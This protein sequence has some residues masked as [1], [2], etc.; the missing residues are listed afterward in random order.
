MLFFSFFPCSRFSARSASGR[1]FLLHVQDL[2][3]ADVPPFNLNN[4]P[5]ERHFEPLFIFLTILLRF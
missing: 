1:G 5:T 2:L 3:T 4:G